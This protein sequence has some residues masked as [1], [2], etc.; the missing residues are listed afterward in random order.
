MPP[1]LGAAAFSDSL[2]GALANL[3]LP[4]DAAPR[5]LL[6]NA[7]VVRDA[8]LR[9]LLGNVTIFSALWIICPVNRVSG[10]AKCSPITQYHERHCPT[11]LRRAQGVIIAAPMGSISQR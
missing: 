3:F 1:V 6:N 2:L 7:L 11:R 4:F 9:R 10:T 8:L 5:R